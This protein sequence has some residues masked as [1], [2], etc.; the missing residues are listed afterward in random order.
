MKRMVAA[1]LGVLATIGIGQPVLAQQD[2]DTAMSAYQ[3]QDYATAMR[4][5]ERRCTSSE[6]I[7]CAFLGFLYLNGEGVRRDARRAQDLLIRGCRG[8]DVRGVHQFNVAGCLLAGQL[9]LG[10]NGGQRDVDDAR[11]FF[12]R[13]CTSNGP[14]NQVNEA[15]YQHALLLRD[16]LGGPRDV[17][18]ASIQLAALCNRNHAAACT[19]LAAIAERGGGASGKP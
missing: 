10:E 19:A 6:A 3:R 18:Q 4:L 9:S 5:W 15:C 7:G 16:G 11:E 13:A 12:G 14:A 8:Y 2:L 17:V 1:L